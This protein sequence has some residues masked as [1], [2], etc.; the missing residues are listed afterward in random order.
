MTTTTSS[1]YRAMSDGQLS[2]MARQ[3]AIRLA[4]VR[5]ST[6]PIGTRLYNEYAAKLAEV[7]AEIERRACD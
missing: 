4:Q 3:L 1:P 6:S 5:D 2:Y 7:R